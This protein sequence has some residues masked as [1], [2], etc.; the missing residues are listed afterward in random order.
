MWL[1]NSCAN[2][3]IEVVALDIN[4]SFRLLRGF[5][6]LVRLIRR[7][8]PDIVQTW[9]Y[10]ADLI[11]GLAARLAGCHKVIWGIRT[12]NIFPG[13]GVART[14]KLDIEVVRYFVEYYPPYNPLCG[15]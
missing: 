1:G 3:G 15:E 5:I 10:H 6:S 14:T 9:M 13:K 2:C 7:Q 12:T 4:S 11:G 8:G